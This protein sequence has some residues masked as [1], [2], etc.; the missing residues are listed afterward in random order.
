MIEKPKRFTQCRLQVHL[1]AQWLALIHDAYRVLPA[2]RAADILSLETWSVFVSSLVVS[3]TECLTWAPPGPS[4]SVLGM[5]TKAQAEPLLC[6][7]CRKAV[8]KHARLLAAADVRGSSTVERCTRQAV[9]SSPSQTHRFLVH[10][11]ALET[12][13]LTDN[14]ERMVCSQAPLRLAW[15]ISAAN[16]FFFL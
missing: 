3:C 8:C 1:G 16:M 9:F 11:G 6:V 5:V 14:S 15:N 12:P 4:R 2:K 10:P 13:R 7:C